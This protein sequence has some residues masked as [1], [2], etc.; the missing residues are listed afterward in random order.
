MIV[1]SKTP[2]GDESKLLI[3]KYLDAFGVK[4]VPPYFPAVFDLQYL[5]EWKAYLKSFSLEIADPEKR[6][7]LLVL[8]FIRYFEHLKMNPFKSPFRHPIKMPSTRFRVQD[9]YER[10]VQEDIKDVAKQAQALLRKTNVAN[11]FRQ[12]K[13]TVTVYRE[14][15]KFFMCSY[16]VLIPQRN[17][18]L[19]DVLKSLQGKLYTMRT[20]PVQLSPAFIRVG[21]KTKSKLPKVEEALA[22]RNDLGWLILDKTPRIRFAITRCQ[23][24]RLVFRTIFECDNSIA[25]GPYDRTV[26]TLKKLWA[27]TFKGIL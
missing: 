20:L 10:L 12:Q 21:N 25:L 8:E 5:P 2:I 24:D 16:H 6:M 13:A 19:D 3:R 18:K 11:T 1:M 15:T 22:S 17:A 7:L 23:K 27:L 4:P 14:G 26:R 9:V